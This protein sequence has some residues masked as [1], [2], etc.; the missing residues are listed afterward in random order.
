MRRTLP[1][2]SHWGIALALV[3]VLVGTLAVGAVG[4]SAQTSPTV[5][6]EEG[7]VATDGQTTLN[8]TLSRAPT[9]IAGYVIVV[10]VEDGSVASVQSARAGVPNNDT[11]VTGDTVTLLGIDRAER[12]DAGDRNVRLG[13][14][15]VAGA[16]DGETNVTVEVRQLDAVDGD[17]ITA[18]TDAGRLLVDDTRSVTVAADG[19]G[20]FASIQTA[21]DAVPADYSV[22]VQDGTYE[23]SLTLDSDVTILA[24]DATLSGSGSSSDAAIEIVGDAEPTVSG[25]AVD[26]WHV[27]VDAGGTTG[28]WTVQNLTVTDT[29]VG[30]LAGPTRSRSARPATGNWT[31]SAADA[32]GPGDVDV[33][34]RNTPGNWSISGSTLDSGVDV[35]RS[36]GAWSISGSTVRAINGS[37]ATVAVNA[38]GTAGNWVIKDTQITEARTAGVFASSSTGDFTLR[39]VTVRTVRKSATEDG[40]GAGLSAAGTS[41]SG[42]WQVIESKFVATGGK[43][44]SADSVSGNW[45]VK[46]SLLAANDGT[47]INAANTANGTVTGNAFVRNDGP[48]VDATNATVNIT[49]N[50][51]STPPDKRCLTAGCDGGLTTP[52]I[53]IPETHVV[54]QNGSADFTSIQAAV[55]AAEP[56]D[57]VLVENGTY[58]ETI[59][60]DAEVDVAAR[61]EGGVVLN[62]T[63][64]DADSGVVLPEDASAGPTVSGLVITEFNNGV[65]ARTNG[66]A[67]RL[68][69]VT[70]TNNDIGINALA[71]TGGWRVDESIIRNNRVGV[72][73][74]ASGERRIRLRQN[75]ITNNTEVGVSATLAQR[76]VDARRNWWGRPSGPTDGQCRDEVDCSAHLTTTNGSGV[77]L[78]VE[79]DGSGDYTT[80]DGAVSAAE[81]GDRV[82]VANGT[83][84][85]QVTIDSDVPVLARHPGSV[86]LI[87]PNPDGSVITIEDDAAPTVDG[88]EITGLTSNNT[89]ISRAVDA[90]GTSGDWT[91]RNLTVRGAGIGVDADG[92][93]GAWTVTNADID[94]TAVSGVRAAYSDGDWTINRTTISNGTTEVSDGVGTQASSGN[95]TISET[96]ITGQQIAGIRTPG[97]DGAPL[98]VDSNLSGNSAGIDASE[99]ISLTIQR[100]V[101]TAN[102]GTGLDARSV[103]SVT[104]STS[105]LLGN[106]GADLNATDAV[107]TVDA[108]NNWWGQSSG[109]EPEQCVGNANCSASLAERPD[110]G[111]PAPDDGDDTGITADIVVA[112]DGSANFTSI[113]N[114]VE[115]ASDG[116]AIRITAGTYDETN[117]SIGTNVTVVSDSGAT[118]VGDGPNSGFESPPAFRIVTGSNAAPTIRGLTFRDHPTAIEAVETNGDWQIENISV[119]RT[120][121]AVR[122]Q[123]SEGAWQVR[124]VSHDGVTGLF[125][126]GV[127]ARSSSGDWIIDGLKTNSTNGSVNAIGTDGAWTVNNSEFVDTGRG[128]QAG[129]TT[130]A[131]TVN[132]TEIRLNRSYT[133]SFGEHPSGVGI[134]AGGSSESWRVAN[135]LILGGGAGIDTR[136]VDKSELPTSANWTVVRSVIANNNDVA[137]DARDTDGA[138]RVNATIIADNGEGINATNAAV[139]GDATTNYWGEQPIPTESQCIGNVNCS[140]PLG[141][142]PENDVSE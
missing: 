25:L 84:E 14:V 45:T 108:T 9:D 18:T 81:D 87:G 47:G 22:S 66:G 78:T 46:G 42:D 126:V 83:Y 32:S 95:W 72:Q 4:A 93:S 1:G 113:Q 103:G 79:P 119:E 13:Q 15:G 64:T 19:S 43:A 114:A 140:S 101:V 53:S 141:S 54:A 48:D 91:L 104:V 2:R 75:Q 28:D 102:G 85:E 6:V 115:A 134:S 90:V 73:A 56:G 38:V 105:V 58:A 107:T 117:V 111:V 121:F 74:G 128:I 138:W 7:I 39:N 80:I 37:S 86:T 135:T 69:N 88:F 49:E 20:D 99:S 82:V 51:W 97:S 106:D 12:I 139:T 30:V 55:D 112:D 5:S 63:M 29:D 92:S 17:R 98:I 11:T 50:Y 71:S 70:V 3:L 16:G 118:V 116:D 132:T 36:T 122:A 33:A 52:P 129:Q 24:D 124:N 31:V 62:G 123:R 130:G 10:S 61:N 34:A 89:R 21:V 76:T 110:V 57:L 77:T 35:A 127:Q 59:R 8:V 44:I 60:L 137:I 94:G 109:P 68:E 27:G 100:S 67:W 40:P 142:P 96:A 136:P 133:I 41:T 125:S 26:D 23:E 131:W 120:R 65:M